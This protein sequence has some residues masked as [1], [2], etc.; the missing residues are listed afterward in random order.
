MESWNI[1]YIRKR[2][3]HIL[4]EEKYDF[5]FTMLPSETTHAH[6]KASAVLALKS[7]E[8]LDEDKR[9]LVFATTINDS[10]DANIEYEELSGYPIT[11]LM[12]KENPFTFDREKKFGHNKR[13]DYKIIANWVIAEHKSQ[14][15]MQLLMNRGNVE[16][17]WPYQLNMSSELSKAAEF[18]K[19]V[20]EVP[21]YKNPDI[22]F[23]IHR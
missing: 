3:Q 2:L 6:H 19:A 15:T 11:R 16:Q 4:E 21:V 18:F 5:I 14:G 10:V 22:N 7:V 8:T 20:N 12:E 1:M 23:G 9:P 13:L 17:Y